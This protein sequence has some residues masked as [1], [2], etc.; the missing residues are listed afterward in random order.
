MLPDERMRRRLW[1]VVL[2]A[3]LWIVV[4][5]WQQYILSANIFGY[6]RWLDG[7]L[8]GPFRGPTAGPKMVKGAPR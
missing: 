7:S 2:A 5:V 6:P 8:S 1:Y 3:A 4:E